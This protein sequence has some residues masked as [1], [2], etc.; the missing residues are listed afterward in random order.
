[1]AISFV[2]SCII[3]LLYIPC[4]HLYMSLHIAIAVVVAKLLAILRY[5]FIAIRNSHYLLNIFVNLVDSPSSI[6]QQPFT[7][8]HSLALFHQQP[9]YLCFLLAS[10][11]QYPFTSTHSLAPFHQCPIICSFSLTLLHQHLFISTPLL[12]AIH[13]HPFPSTPSLTVFHQQPFTS[14]L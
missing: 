2:E 6:Y 8:T 12:P 7:D 11:H 13:Q 10:L 1:M 5:F 4:P 9:F 3:L 14:T